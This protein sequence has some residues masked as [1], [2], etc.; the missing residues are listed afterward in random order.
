MSLYMFCSAVH[1]FFIQV[2]HKQYYKQLGKVEKICE[3]IIKDRYVHVVPPR[4]FVSPRYNA[5]ILQ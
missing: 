1:L 4:L 5:S 2:V 3:E